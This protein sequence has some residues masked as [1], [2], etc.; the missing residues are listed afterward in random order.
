MDSPPELSPYLSSNLPLPHGLKPTL[1]T[2]L[3]KTSNCIAELDAEIDQL[4]RALDAKRREREKYKQAHEEHS[5]LQAPIRSIPPEIWGIIF[6]FTLGHEPFS[7]WEYRMY[8]YLRQVCWSWR[9]VVSATPELCRGLVVDLD[10]PLAQA[11]NSNEE[12]LRCLKKRLESWLAIV[13]RNHPYHL[14]LSLE[15]GDSFEWS[16][17][18]T[19]VVQWILTT[20]PSPTI[21]SLVT[22]ACR[23]GYLG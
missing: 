5:R 14:F 11:S 2:Y 15:D 12:G 9:D 13:S 4:E 19:E 10:G 21:L 1:G 8:G 16:E 6:G 18:V 7:L 3:A 23:P 22:S 17:D 20:G